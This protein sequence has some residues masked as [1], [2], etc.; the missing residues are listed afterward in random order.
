[1]RFVI[2]IRP[3]SHKCRAFSL[4]EMLVA[5]AVIAI[6]A[7]IAIPNIGGVFQASEKEVATRNLNMINAALNS[8]SQAYYDLSGSTA[9]TIDVLRSLQYRDPNN[10]LPGTPFLSQTMNFVSTSSTDTYRAEWS[11]NAFIMHTKGASGT[12]IDLLKMSETVSADNGT[13]LADPN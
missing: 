13:L 10:P 8:F 1:M 2:P 7:T 3:V 9:D 4:Q 11:N 12:G 6:F 5:V